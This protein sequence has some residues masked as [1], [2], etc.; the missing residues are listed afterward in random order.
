MDEEE[1]DE[2]ATVQDLTRIRHELQYE[3]MKINGEL[4]KARERIRK[5]ENRLDLNP[6]RI[7]YSPE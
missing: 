5:L 2:V 3:V 7:G 1:A 6:N 4:A